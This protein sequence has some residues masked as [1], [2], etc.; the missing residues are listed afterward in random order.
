[1]RMTTTHF[2]SWF[3]AM[4]RLAPLL[5]VMTL[6]ACATPGDAPP[7]RFDSLGDQGFTVTQ[8]V[9]LSGGLRSDFEKAIRHIDA[10]EFESGIE[11]LEKVTAE[12]PAAAAAHINLAIGYA[13]IDNLERAEA[14]LSVALAL[15]P[16]HPAALNEL[17]IVYRRTG[18]FEQARESY[19]AALR[20]YPRFHFARRNLAIL[21]DLY[22]GDLE[23]AIEN[24]ELYTQA[25]PEDE[26]AAMWIVDLRNRN[27]R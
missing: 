18:R 26:S 12:A 5:L 25:M 6:A 22:L 23:C 2:H 16:E 17:G 7:A 10:E 24:Y 14:S 13:H 4:K 27:G 21:C 3:R 11:L 1:M 15:A 19:E 8:D 20:I 9:R